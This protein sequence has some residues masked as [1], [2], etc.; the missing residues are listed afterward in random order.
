[1]PTESNLTRNII[2]SGLRYRSKRRI[3]KLLGKQEETRGI[4]RSRMT[5][6]D[7]QADDDYSDIRSIK[8][9]KRR[10]LDLL[11]NEE[12]PFLLACDENSAMSVQSHISRKFRKRKVM[13]MKFD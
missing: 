5:S 1:M 2:P 3:N 9:N 13:P 12:L 7:M 8:S 6:F 10:R 4:T 11:R